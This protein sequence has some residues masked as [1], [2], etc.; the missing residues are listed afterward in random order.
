[1]LKHLKY[2]L[3]AQLVLASFTYGNISDTEDENFEDNDEIAYD[4][5]ENG[6]EDVVPSSFSVNQQN[7]QPMPQKAISPV[8][9]PS[10]HYKFFGEML[11]LKPYFQGMISFVKSNQSQ[12]SSSLSATTTFQKRIDKDLGFDLDFDFGFRVGFS[13]KSHW[14]D[15]ENQLIWMRFHTSTSH[16]F[17][18]SVFF[19]KTYYAYWNNSFAEPCGKTYKP[20]YRSKIDWDVID[21]VS[22]V[23]LHPIQRFIVAPKLGIRGLI[24]E[25]RNKMNNIK[26]EWGC[27]GVFV[28]TPPL[29]TQIN[30][31]SEKYNAIG[32][33][34]GFDTD[35][36]IGIGFHFDTIF[37]ASLVFGEMHVKN[38]SNKIVPIQRPDSYPTTYL[39]KDRY[40]LLQPLIDTQLLLSWKKKCFR[41]KVGFDVYAGYE[42]HY[43]P[44]FLQMIRLKD[45]GDEI[46]QFDMSMQGITAGM[47]ISF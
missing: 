38:L 1:M 14:L 30:T 45:S 24:S 42:L 23:P 11:Y 34:G 29:N 32:L 6:R 4:D 5:Q 15:V 3:S 35:T 8:S 10:C 2:I 13:F 7:A 36:D 12:Y 26:A 40:Y 31:I 22:K 47:A 25:V 17:S 27:N 44:D 41:N 20:S 43:M 46:E 9:Q 33:L 16:H 28:F 39:A 19:S 18:H 21:L 37:N